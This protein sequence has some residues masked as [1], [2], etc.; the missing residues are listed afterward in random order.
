V[1]KEEGRKMGMDEKI[2][3]K[4]TYLTF[5]DAPC[6]LQVCGLSYIFENLFSGKTFSSEIVSCMV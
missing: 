3:Q 2:A 1:G 4:A 5:E 6:G